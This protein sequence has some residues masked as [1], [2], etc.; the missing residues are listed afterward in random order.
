MGSKHVINGRQSC[1]FLTSQ[2]EE[3]YKDRCAHPDAIGSKC[4]RVTLLDRTYEDV[5]PEYCPWL[6]GSECVVVAAPIVATCRREFEAAQNL[7]GNAQVL[8]RD[9]K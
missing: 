6:C 1:L 9:V 8:L 4:D 5:V 2:S 7:I 3:G